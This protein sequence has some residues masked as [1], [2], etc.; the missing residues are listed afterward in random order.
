MALA[1]V[2]ATAFFTTLAGFFCAKPM[3][4]TILKHPIKNTLRI[5]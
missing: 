2:L 5:L 4:E 1:V 3:N